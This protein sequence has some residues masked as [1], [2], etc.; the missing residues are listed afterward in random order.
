MNN[1]TQINSEMNA[2]VIN[3][4]IGQATAINPNLTSVST[5]LSAG[6]LLAGKYEIIEPLSVSTGE[7]DLYVCKYNDKEYVAKVYRRQRAVK[8]EVI[9]V[10]KSISS[11]YVASLY[12]TGTH[13]NL[14]FEVLPYY[15]NGSLQGRQFSMEELKNRLIGRNTDTEDVIKKR[16]DTAVWEI[17]QAKN[18]DYV[19]VN[20]TIDTAT[21]TFLAI[22]EGE[23]CSTKRN[24]NLLK[25]YK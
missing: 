16:L 25:N 3:S 15:K 17:K 13:N 2:T 1:R 5:K 11:P 10:L 7:A 21:N 9:T 22:I 23:K 8:P 18:Y 20:D 6:T 19:L 14:P 24:E 12:D 4:E